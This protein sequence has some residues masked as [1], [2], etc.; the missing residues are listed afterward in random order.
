MA[1]RS[2]NKVTLI[3]RLG[4]DAEQKFTQSGTAV[5]TYSIATSQRFKDASGE[6]KDK[7]DW[8]NLVQWR[9]ENVIDYL[10]K[11]SKVY[12]EGHLQTRNYENK[13]GR[14]VYITEVV[15]EEM[16]LLGGKEDRGTPSGAE[17]YDRPKNGAAPK[18]ADPPFDSGAEAGL[19]ITDDDVPF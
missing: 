15:V 11:G 7:T 5:A 2:V 19:G 14:K 18:P 3:G 12:I 16:I 1:E 8:H 9:T 6:W 17:Q 10:K 4:K 13:E